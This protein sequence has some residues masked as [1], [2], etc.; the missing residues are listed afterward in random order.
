MPAT[1]R[2]DRDQVP[3]QFGMIL[4]HE[5]MALQ[6]GLG[7]SVTWLVASGRKAEH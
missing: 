3:R 5:D 7:D 6:G 2:W 4:A 1:L